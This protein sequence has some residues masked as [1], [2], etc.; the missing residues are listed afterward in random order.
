[1]KLNANI[2]RML[3]TISNKSTTELDWDNFVF[4][5][6]KNKEL[7]ACD[8][9]QMLLIRNCDLGYN[10]NVAIDIHNTKINKDLVLFDYG[11][12]DY[13]NY[14]KVISQHYDETFDNLND[15]LHYKELKF[16]FYNQKIINFLIKFTY[17]E[18]NLKFHCN[19][20]NYCITGIKY[21]YVFTYMFMP[22]LN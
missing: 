22:I 6:S 7:V 13:P 9:H 17:N 10:K 11:I 4:Y 12:R 19:K 2:H 16:P 1:M 8:K 18:K 5:N 21:R 3:K 15:L 20:Y 14:Q